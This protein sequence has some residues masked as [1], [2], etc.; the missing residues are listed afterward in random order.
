MT[1][2]DGNLTEMIAAV[3]RS[4]PRKREFCLVTFRRAQKHENAPRAGVL[5]A[6]VSAQEA[7][8]SRR[9]RCEVAS[10]NGEFSDARRADTAKSAI[11]RALFLKGGTRSE[12]TRGINEDSKGIHRCKILRDRSWKSLVCS[13]AIGALLRSFLSS[14]RRKP[15][16]ERLDTDSETGRTPSRPEESGMRE[17]Q[18]KEQSL[19][20]ERCPD[21]AT[22]S[23]SLQAEALEFVQ[24]SL[25]PTCSGALVAALVLLPACFGHPSRNSS[26]P[27][28]L[29]GAFGRSSWSLLS[30]SWLLVLFS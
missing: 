5:R 23:T 4:Q 18:S 8:S 3:L 12:C 26:P 29:S 14:F 17:I 25:F 20:A 30:C 2:F 28:Y 27:G 21:T 6:R 11:P 19:G 10:E 1:V 16:N 15:S 24:I 7:S 13:A 9:R 22:G